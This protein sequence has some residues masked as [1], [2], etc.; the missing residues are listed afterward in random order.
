ME[1]PHSN[2]P[3]AREQSGRP[4]NQS[5]LDETIAIVPGQASDPILA[6]DVSYT[7]IIHFLSP[8]SVVKLTNSFH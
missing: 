7:M 5:S 3:A 1:G 2:G 6:I 8:Q 4:L